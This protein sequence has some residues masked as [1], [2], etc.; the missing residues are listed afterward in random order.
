MSNVHRY[1]LASTYGW[2]YG[3]WDIYTLPS[4][5]HFWCHRTFEA[6]EPNDTRW[7]ICKSAGILA[8]LRDIHSYMHEV[9]EVRPDYYLGVRKVAWDI[10]T[11]PQ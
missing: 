6:T 7:G 11:T 5:A 8:A 10:T 2:T 1:L 9:N 4:G 3:E